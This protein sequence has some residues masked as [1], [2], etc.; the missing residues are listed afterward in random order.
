MLFSTLFL[1]L[2]CNCAVLVAVRTK[3][4]KPN[5]LFMLIDDL[6]W[7]DIG[8]H[9]TSA[10]QSTNIDKLASTGEHF[11]GFEYMAKY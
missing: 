10:I 11:C 3:R 7:N 2:I 4:S 8:F 6:G 1:L 9:N 5:I